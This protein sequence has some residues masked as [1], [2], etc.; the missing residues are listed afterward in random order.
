LGRRQ[1]RLHEAISKTTPYLFTLL[2]AIVVASILIAI[3]LSRVFVRPIQK[4]AENLGQPELID[5]EE[6]YKEIAPL[7]K[8]IR[9]QHR[10]LQLTIEQLTIEKKKTTQ[11]RDEFTA[12]ASHELK[13]PLTSI[14]GYA[15]LIENGLAKPED[16]RRLGGKIHKEANRLLAIAND[17]MML[18]KLDS[19]RDATLDLNE[20]VDLGQ[21]ACDCV[22]E[23]S[24]NANKKNVKLSVECDG[25]GNING[26][27]RLLF[28]M[29]YNLIDNAI[30]YTEQG[31]NAKVVV[32]KKS[33]CV[34]DTGIGIP[35]EDRSRIFERFYRVDKSRSKESGG[36]GL[37]LAIVKHIAEVHQAKISLKSIVGIGTEIKVEFE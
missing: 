27:Y 4:L 9:K 20:N 32:E 5:D 14:S 36:T 1:A 17:I 23:L 22:D 18:S 15:E 25:A 24:L 34:K 13:T 31:G 35:E 28:E 21:L 10:E 12:N 2:A 3:G 6:T 11:M 33:V 29:L 26:N 8:T 7:V 19:P 37:G 30:R 16:V